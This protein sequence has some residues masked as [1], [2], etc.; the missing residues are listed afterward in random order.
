MAI[1]YTKSDILRK[2]LNITKALHI[3]NSRNL[4]TLILGFA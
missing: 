3:I 2:R 4:T 1:T